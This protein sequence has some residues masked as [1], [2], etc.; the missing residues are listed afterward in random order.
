MVYAI[1]LFKDEK[2]AFYLLNTFIPSA[3]YGQQ[4]WHIGLEASNKQKSM[5]QLN[6]LLRRLMERSNNPEHLF[7]PHSAMNTVA[8]AIMEIIKKEAI[9][10]VVM[11][12]K[13]ATGAKNIIFGSNT[14]E[15]IRKTE[16]PVIAVPS[17]FEYKPPKNILFATDYE[18]S[19][20]KTLL[21]VPLNIAEHYV[22]HIAVLHVPYPSGLTE[23]QQ[24][25]RITLEE[26]LELVD[27]KSHL[28]T[29]ENVRSAINDFQVKENID[30]LVMV[31][32]KHTFL[33][34]LF[35]I[36]NIKQIGLEIKVPFLVVP[37]P[38]EPAP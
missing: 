10:L 28:V 33:E 24:N 35:K 22:S 14:T 32:N 1:N 6:A 8:G 19:Y 2:C 36:S 20:S 15:V 18:I 37:C 5:K 3:H 16:C 12:T 30:L 11:G 23:Y 7:V 9:D 21:K 38:S 17:G 13:G 29:H 4:S 27:Y 26:V 25:N 31:Q 34:R